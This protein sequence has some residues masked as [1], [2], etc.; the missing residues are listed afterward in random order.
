MS[1]NLFSFL[2]APAA[3]LT[4][5]HAVAATAPSERKKERK[6]YV[7]FNSSSIGLLETLLFHNLLKR[8]RELIV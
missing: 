4:A 3:F 6:V 1:P 8:L 2:L 5:S 7:Y